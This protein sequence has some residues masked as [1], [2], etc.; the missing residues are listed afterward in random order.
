MRKSN[1]LPSF[2]L[3][4]MVIVIGGFWLSSSFEPLVFDR[5]NVVFQVPKNVI[6]WLL[7]GAFL[8]TFTTFYLLWKNRCFDC[9]DKMFI[10]KSDF[11]ISL[12]ITIFLNF[13]PFFLLLLAS[14]I[15]INGFF[16]RSPSYQI[17]NMIIDKN[18]HHSSKGDTTYWLTL[19]NT[20]NLI[21]LPVKGEEY[22]RTNCDDNVIITAKKG[23]FNVAWRENYKIISQS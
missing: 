20:Q 21:Y 13:M 12:F 9:Q 3:L 6:K 8:L 2:A 16:D 22:E 19:K 10:E 4:L 1:I 14:F 11:L 17:Q 7:F 5:E 15:F 18:Q 23:W